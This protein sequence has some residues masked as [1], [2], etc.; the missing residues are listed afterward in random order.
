ML[1]IWQ[2]WKRKRK[3]LK[4]KVVVSV[5]RLLRMNATLTENKEPLAPGERI[6]MQYKLADKVGLL[7]DV[8]NPFLERWAVRHD[9]PRNF[10]YAMFQDD[11][12][13]FVRME[14]PPITNHRTKAVQRIIKKG[15]KAGGKYLGTRTT[16]I[17]KA[18]QRAIHFVTLYEMKSARRAMFQGPL[19]A[20]LL[21]FR[22]R[23]AGDIFDR[24][25]DVFDGM[26]GSVYENDSQFP[27]FHATYFDNDKENA[28]IEI[29]IKPYS[30]VPSC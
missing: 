2:A 25:K 26:Q 1:R 8:S 21:F 30:G 23:K 12:S 10:W 27:D 3:N 13:L 14:V 4:Q 28:R 19:A 18:Y 24:W 11:G 6:K 29:T 9:G 20:R 7:F 5:E 17:T 16:E 22:E 15:P